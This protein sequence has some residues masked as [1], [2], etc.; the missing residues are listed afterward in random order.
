[1]VLV[2]SWAGAACIGSRPRSSQPLPPPSSGM[3]YMH[4]NAGAI[5][6]SC[7]SIRGH[8][9]EVNMESMSV[10]GA[11]ELPELKRFKTNGENRC[12]VWSFAMKT[13]LIKE[14]VAAVQLFTEHLLLHQVCV[15][16]FLDG[17]VTYPAT[18]VVAGAAVLRVPEMVVVATKL[19][20]SSHANS[21][22]VSTV[23]V[24]SSRPESTWVTKP[25]FI[26]ERIPVLWLLLCGL[27]VL[28][29]LAGHVAA[30]PAS[31]RNAKRKPRHPMSKNS[32]TGFF[33]KIPTYFGNPGVD[34]TSDM[35]QNWGDALG[36]MG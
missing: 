3:P 36:I 9:I 17:V 27:V 22:E 35:G 20:T 33:S 30:T 25:T 8:R 24:T 6:Y 14:S 28:C 1:M 26:M 32:T 5:L 13:R 7:Y 4:H 23:I 31:K 11:A 16:F 29:R 12:S 21:A 34:A 15:A 2:Y 19:V 10:R 18:G